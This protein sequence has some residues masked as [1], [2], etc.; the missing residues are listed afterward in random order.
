[1]RKVDPLLTYSNG[2]PDFFHLKCENLD[3]AWQKTG[4]P[5][6]LLVSNKKLFT[7]GF[8]DNGGRTM[9]SDLNKR[10]EFCHQAPSPHRMDPFATIEMSVYRSAFIVVMILE[11]SKYVKHLLAAW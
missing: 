9:S 2:K 8:I 1:M 7:S 10:C 11:L 3:P 6:E 5:A 4:S